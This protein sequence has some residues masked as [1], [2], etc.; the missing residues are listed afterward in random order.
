MDISGV[1]S[2]YADYMT[3]QASNSKA[4]TL[5]NKL[6]NGSTV[7]DEEELKEACKE[8]E[9]YFV[10]QVFNAMME[11]TKVFSDDKEDGYATK[12]VDY[13]KDFAVQ[14]L[15]DNVTD[16]DGLGLANILYEQMKRNYGIGVVQPEALSEE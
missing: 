3:S 5:Q 15:C 12:M 4:E 11:T 16:G 2:V 10:E 13:F 1:G 7:T 9:S 8:F 14:E 6:A